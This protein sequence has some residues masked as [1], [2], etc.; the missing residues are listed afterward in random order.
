MN[1]TIKLQYP[2]TING[3][4]Y[5]ELNMRRSKV[6]DRLAVANMKDKSEEE[7]EILL[8]ANLCEVSP[9]VI[10]ELDESDYPAVQQVYVGF[11]GSAA[12]SAAK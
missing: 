4:E 10:R 3:T 12:T 6:K 9:D 1:Q 2:V 7:K 5:K 8:F 11:F